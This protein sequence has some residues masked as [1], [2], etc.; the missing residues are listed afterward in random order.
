MCAHEEELPNLR[1][2]DVVRSQCIRRLFTR[3]LHD[4]NGS[5]GE[6]WKR[7]LGQRPTD[8]SVSFT[9]KSEEE[10]ADVRH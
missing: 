7:G 1:F 6:E 9:V 10:D 5:Y 3:A 2:I 8:I 4:H